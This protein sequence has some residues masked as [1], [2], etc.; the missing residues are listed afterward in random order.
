MDKDAEVDFVLDRR[1]TTHGVSY[2]VKFVGESCNDGALMPAHKVPY[3]KRCEFEQ[4]EGQLVSRV[5]PADSLKILINSKDKL[6]NHFKNANHVEKVASH[7]KDECLP[8][9]TK[10]H[11]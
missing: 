9:S 2:M 11:A 8:R 5:Y 3:E 4:K 1:Y 10:C 6:R 7:K